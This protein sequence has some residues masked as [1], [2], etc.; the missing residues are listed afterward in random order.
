MNRIEFMK[1]LER[2]LQN[3]PAEERND[4][5]QYYEGYFEDAGPDKEQEVI[6]ELKSPEHV[7]QIILEDAGQDGMDSENN[8]QTQ[9]QNMYQNQGYSQDM[10]NSQ[11]YNQNSYNNQGYNQNYNQ[12]SM[13]STT[14]TIVIV[15]LIVTAP[16]T[17]PIIFS[18]IATMIGVFLGIFG[19][20]IGFFAGAVGL[21]IG[22]GVL[23]SVGLAGLGFWLFGIGSIMIGISFLLMPLAGWVCKTAIPEVVKC[24]KRAVY[25]ATHKG[26]NA[27]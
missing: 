27:A 22:G 10:Y 23:I 21:F 11:G 5:L 20:I 7:A 16:V 8:T 9:G 17:I 2:L 26:G 6:R 3:L 25:K 13:D 19:I 14:R 1:Q 15:L 24:M 18:I 12:K 4:A